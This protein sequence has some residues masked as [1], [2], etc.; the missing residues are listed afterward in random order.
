[1]MHEATLRER[2]AFVQR[3]LEGIEHELCPGMT[4]NPQPTIRRANASMMIA[5]GDPSATQPVTSHRRATYAKPCQV[6]T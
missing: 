4:G 6:E 1:M 5:S 3:L 2:L